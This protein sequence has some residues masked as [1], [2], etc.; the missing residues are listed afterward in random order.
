MT[1]PLLSALCLGGLLL[2]A[3]SDRAPDP[4]AQAPATAA[5][6]AGDFVVWV[7]ATGTVE[8]ASE[9]EVKSKAS[10]EIVEF[11]FEAGDPV[12][13]G[14]L[15][16]RL[17]PSDEERSVER[18]EAE[19]RSAD[20]RLEASRAELRLAEVEQRQALREAAAAG[21]EA[22][23]R[24]AEAEARLARDEELLL[25]GVVSREEAQVSQTR[26]AEARAGA[27][28][29][30]AALARARSREHAVERARQDVLQA[31]AAR[32]SARLV[33]DEAR[34]RL[35]DTRILAPLTGV[36]T[37][38]RVEQGQVISSAIS[39][40]GGGTTLLKIADLSRLY[41]KLSVD[42]VDIAR[43]RPGQ[44]SRVAADAL[45]ERSW[46]GR[47]EQIAPVGV[48]EQKVVQFTVRVSVEG[49]GAGLLRPGMTANV[50]VETARSDA[51]LWVPRDALDPDGATVQVAASGGEEP[52]ER[53]VVTGLRDAH[54]VEIREGLAAG[55]RVV[56]RPA[57]G[58]GPW[59]RG[60][61]GA[62]ASTTRFL[63][64]LRK[65]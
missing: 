39:N 34:K 13:A 40:V 5:V 61:P 18:R 56:L 4:A 47:V 43:L 17:D 33:L 51:T 60:A 62:A 19:L 8:A 22:R 41:V 7:A 14:Q 24:A 23:A 25:K 65:K 1:R 15:V 38:T 9:V 35:A 45:P 31:E 63:W 49:D 44:P 10:G 11:P 32:T 12:R 55:E 42:E 2:A 3:C 27:E 21:A 36:V 52:A 28:R 29:A 48:E 57:G 26:L 58:G 53:R 37:E 59:R 30:E 50:E 46:A 16:C 6:E 20:A 64:G 54:R